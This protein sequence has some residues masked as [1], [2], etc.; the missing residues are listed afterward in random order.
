VMFVSCGLSSDAQPPQAFEVQVSLDAKFWTVVAV[1]P[2]SES[3]AA[4]YAA[5]SAREPCF[6]AFHC[7]CRQHSLISVVVHLGGR[8][9]LHCHIICETFLQR[10][11][12]RLQVQHYPDL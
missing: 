8:S 5:A 1:V 11:M 7:R 9:P 12:S 10:L 4:V 3:I 6:P 2:E